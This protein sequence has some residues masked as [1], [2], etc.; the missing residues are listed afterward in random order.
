MICGS[1]QFARPGCPCQLGCCYEK[2]KGEEHCHKCEGTGLCLQGHAG[3][4]ML[5]TV[6][7]LPA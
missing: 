7:S 1:D 6:S 2:E 5:Y 4:A 3:K